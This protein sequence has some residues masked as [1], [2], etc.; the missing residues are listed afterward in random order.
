METKR[1][2]ITKQETDKL[3]NY[4]GDPL[5][6]YTTLD[7]GLVEVDRED[8]RVDQFGAYVTKFIPKSTPEGSK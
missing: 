1:Y 6:P 2:Y 8:I 5:H 3:W 7:V 4:V